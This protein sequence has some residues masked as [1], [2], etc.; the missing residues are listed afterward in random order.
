MAIYNFVWISFVV[1]RRLHIK[2][3]LLDA[4]HGAILASFVRN[5]YDLCNYDIDEMYNSNKQAWKD[6]FEK[7][8]FKIAVQ[9]CELSRAKLELLPLHLQLM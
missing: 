6:K 4:L 5:T 7:N 9:R 8:T 1:F 2:I 3:Y